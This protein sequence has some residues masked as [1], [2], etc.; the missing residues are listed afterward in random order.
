VFV[1][2]SSEL[3]PLSLLIAATM[4]GYL[5]WN[6]H[7]ARALMGDAGSVPLGFLIGWLMLDLSVRGYLAA[8]VIL[9]L[10]FLADSTYTLLV[11]LLR[12]KAPHEP[13]REHFYQRA[14]LAC[15]NHARVVVTV[16]LA[17]AAL[18]VLSLLSVSRPE[19]AVVLA[20]GVG[21]TVLATLERMT[22][23][24]RR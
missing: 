2:T 20:C 6:W 24:S 3:L 7:P 12:R 22:R 4:L 9:P 19:V 1:G 10:Y 14:A 16:V 18:V 11:R 13:H 15:G 17:N 5:A 8:A 23:S 21:L